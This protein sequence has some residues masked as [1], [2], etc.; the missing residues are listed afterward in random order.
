MIKTQTLHDFRSR[1][2][3][4]ATPGFSS[5]PQAGQAT[6]ALVPALTLEQK[7]AISHCIAQHAHEPGALLPL[8]HA[9]QHAL[10][11]IPRGA[12]ALIA[13]AV[14]LSR[15]EVHGVISYYP[16]F[17]EQP[18]GR[19]LV[20]ICRAEACQSRGADALLAHAERVLGC[21]QNT[22]RSDRAVTLEPVYCLGL[23]A[24]SPA[25]MVNESELHARMTPAKFDQLATQWVSSELQEKSEA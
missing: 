21:G 5:S 22:T 17:R 8:L 11:Y 9:V 6:A 7:N 10:T 18:A 13:E 14:N 23:C 1:N 12:I 15:A 25:L 3:A 4:E 2:N 16:H 24:Q 20:Q 19:T